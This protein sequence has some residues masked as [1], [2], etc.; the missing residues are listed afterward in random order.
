M[1]VIPP[2]V[3]IQPVDKLI[4]CPPY[5]EPNDHWVYDT[6]TGAASRAGKRRPAS[7]WY[8]T[9]RTGSAQ[10]SLPGMAEEERDDLPLINLLRDDVRRW[11]EAKYRGASPV[12]KELLNWWA[13][14]KR[15][16]RLFFCQREAVETI[17]YLAE[18]RIPGK[19]GRTGF[20]NFE[21][22]DENLA[23]L[24]KGEKPRLA[25]LSNPNFWP[26]LADT[27]FDQNLMPLC[28]LG[29]KMA[30]GSGKTVVMAH[31]IS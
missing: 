21:L 20:K 24:L 2:Y 13:N 8:K 26:T 14:P 19:S 31:L 22:S 16:R 30:T 1:P 11:R 23:L 28:R 15:G 27:P 17:V 18:L 6:E 12:T 25:N 4:I 29:C 7:Y 3:P 5:D 9:Q 10:Q